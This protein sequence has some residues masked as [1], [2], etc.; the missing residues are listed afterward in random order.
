MCRCRSGNSFRLF[1]DLT[2]IP[3]RN[4]GSNHLST[5]P[6]MSITIALWDHGVKISDRSISWTVGFCTTLFLRPSRSYVA[7]A[8]P[9]RMVLLPPR[10]ACPWCPSLSALRF[11]VPGAPGHRGTGAPKSL[12]IVDKPRECSIHC[13]RIVFNNLGVKWQ[14]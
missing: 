3:F 10:R 1:M 7:P 6:T 12:L 9:G 2:N 11:V 13:P 14:I 8:E 4:T 5:F